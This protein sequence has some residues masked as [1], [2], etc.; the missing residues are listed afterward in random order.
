ML[1]EGEQIIFQIIY[2]LFSLRIKTAIK[3]Y[4]QQVEAKNVECWVLNSQILCLEEPKDICFRSWTKAV[5]SLGSLR[6]YSESSELP[7]FILQSIR[8]PKANVPSCRHCQTGLWY[9]VCALGRRHLMYTAVW[10]WI[11]DPHFAW[12]SVCQLITALHWFSVECNLWLPVYYSEFSEHNHHINNDSTGSILRALPLWKPHLDNECWNYCTF[13][14]TIF[15][16]LK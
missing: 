7:C 14:W 5:L 13:H 1:H 4:D 12:L 9:T 16:W 3:L 10:R 15:A 6:F 2:Y 11:K 8:R